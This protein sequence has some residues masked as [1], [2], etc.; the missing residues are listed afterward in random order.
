VPYKDR[1][2]QKLAQKE[3]YQRNKER[4]REVHAAYRKENKPR[5]IAWLKHYLAYGVESSTQR[6]FS[7]T[8]ATR[9]RRGSPSLRPYAYVLTG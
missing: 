1:E 2:Q 7:S 3:W 6:V 8:I 4:L 9:W 5:L